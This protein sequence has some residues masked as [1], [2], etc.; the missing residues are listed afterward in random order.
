MDKKFNEIHKTFDPHEIINYTVQHNTI[1]KTQTTSYNI[2]KH[3]H[4]L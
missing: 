1:N 4:T 2:I 3:K